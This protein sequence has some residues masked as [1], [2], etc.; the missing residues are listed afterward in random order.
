MSKKSSMKSPVRERV[1]VPKVVKDK[2]GNA[3]LMCP[4]CNPSHALRADGVSPCGTFVRVQA[5]QTVFKSKY[6]KK[7]V[8]CVKCGKS[9]G[10]MVAWQ[11]NAFVHVANCSPATVTLAEPPKYSRLASLV[12]SLPIWAKKPIQKITGEAMKVDEVM[13]D[14]T[15]TGVTLGHAFM[16]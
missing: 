6:A 2:D 4:Y 10:E 15:R 7:D 9:G 13:P 1:E 5:V 3:I 8:K 16:R 14:G 12:Y 11:G